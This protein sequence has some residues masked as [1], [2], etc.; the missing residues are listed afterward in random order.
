MSQAQPLTW[1]EIDTVLLDM[2]GT[3]LDL[4]YD[5]HFWL[6]HLP[7]RYAQIHQLDIDFSRQFL[8]RQLRLN[9]GTINWYCVDF[10]SAKLNV[11][12][13]ALRAEVASKVAFRPFAQEFLQALQSSAKKVVLVTNDHRSGLQMKLARL[14]FGKYLDAIVVSHDFSLAKEQPGFW[15]RMQAIEPFDPG[16]ALF[17]DDTVAVLAE[18]EQYGIAQLR[19]IAQPDSKINREPN[20]RFTAVECFSQ[21][22]KQLQCG[23]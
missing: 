4:H 7:V 23:Q 16:R 22:A 17:I 9:R 19:Y 13:A 15:Q 6:Q 21:Y 18:A 3:L 20:Q 10:W 5:S 11:D 12:I 14:G 1:S 2:D 8:D